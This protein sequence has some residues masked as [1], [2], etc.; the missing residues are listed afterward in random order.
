MAVPD[1]YPI[2]YIQ[3]FASSL[4]GCKTSK[5]AYPNIPENAAEIPKTA[6]TTPFGAFEFLTMPFALR[7]A[8]GTFQSFMD[9]VV[10]DLDFITT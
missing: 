10:R 9:E 5:L 7:S 3:D 1:R 8:A 2:L 6:V 4:R